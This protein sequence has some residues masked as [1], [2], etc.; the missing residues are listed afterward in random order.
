LG[1]N[2][3]E[4]LQKDIDLNKIICYYYRRMSISTR[5]FFIAGIYMGLIFIISSIPG[6]SLPKVAISDKF[7]HFVEFGILSWILG[8]AF[9]TSNKKIFIKQ[10]AILSII[11]TIFYGITDEIHQSFISSRYV[12][13]YDAV[14]DGIGAVLAQGI[15][16]IKKKGR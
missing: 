8:K 13:C 6:E 3:G 16:L 11:I 2:L 4:K 14:C 15:F 5:Y 10:S 1:K 7:I 12:E 9:R